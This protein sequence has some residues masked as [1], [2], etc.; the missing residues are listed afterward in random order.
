MKDGLMMCFFC[1]CL[2]CGFGVKK[3]SECCDVD[4]KNEKAEAP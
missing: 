4:T 3:I 1:P 2:L